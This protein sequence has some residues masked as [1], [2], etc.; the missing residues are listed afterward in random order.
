[1]SNHAY[2]L[3]KENFL[4][5]GLPDECLVELSKGTRVQNFPAETILFNQGETPDFLYI[6]IEGSFELFVADADGNETVVEISSAP[7]AYTV[8]AV[9]TGA[10]YIV[11][12]RILKK[13]RLLMLDARELTECVSKYPVFCQNLLGHLTWQFRTMVRQVVSLKTK[14]TAERLGCY[15]LNLWDDKEKQE[16]IVLP[17]DNRRLATRLGMTTVSLSRAFKILNN[18]GITHTGKNIR[19]TDENTLR[20]YCQPDKF[21]NDHEGPLPLR[22]MTQIRK[23]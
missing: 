7:N 21:L 16:D 18:H 1:M 6:A 20:A 14:T 11:S 23:N 19:I 4:F 3:L 22:R 10:P 15:L 13:A 9:L 12:G 2:S 17:Y 8:G 5:Q